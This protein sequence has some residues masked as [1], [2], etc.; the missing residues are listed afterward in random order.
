[1][2]AELETLLGRARLWLGRPCRCPEEGAICTVCALARDIGEYLDR[3]R[4][5]QALPVEAA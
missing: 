2:S 3:A 5:E 1:M 4:V